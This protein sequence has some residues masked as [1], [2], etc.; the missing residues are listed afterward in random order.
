MVMNLL[1]M[2]MTVTILELQK[3]LPCYPVLLL[4]IGIGL[5]D[6]TSIIRKNVAEGF[7]PKRD[8]MA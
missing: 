4:E 6:L 7:P 3:V 8:E 2:F 5:H 1:F